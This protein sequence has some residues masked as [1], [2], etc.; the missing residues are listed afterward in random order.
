MGQ[1]ART[2]DALPGDQAYF[3]KHRVVEGESG[4]KLEFWLDRRA[5]AGGHIAPP[6]LLAAVGSRKHDKARWKYESDDAF[7]SAEGQPWSSAVQAFEGTSCARVKEWLRWLVD[8]IP[9]TASVE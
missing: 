1:P 5:S 7:V 2:A 3:S 4:C 9:A 8:H 6:P